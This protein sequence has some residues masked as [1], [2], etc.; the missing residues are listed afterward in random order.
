MTVLPLTEL[1]VSLRLSTTAVHN[2]VILQ[3][4]ILIPFLGLLIQIALRILMMAAVTWF[5]TPSLKRPG[6]RHMLLQAGPII[7]M[8]QEML[9]LKNITLL[10]RPVHWFSREQ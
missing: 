10:T 6:L 5:L 7:L 4:F 3:V 2:P 9:Q 8:P 1:T